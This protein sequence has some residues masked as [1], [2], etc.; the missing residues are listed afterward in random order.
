MENH[1]GRKLLRTEHVHHINEIKSDNRLENLSIIDE[2]A[3]HREHVS[4]AF[5]IEQAKI[6]YDSGI[7]YRKLSDI[8]GVARQ[9]IR[10]C[11]VRRGWHVLGRT[12][13]NV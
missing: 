3:H 4:P 2:S 9:N 10:A 1:I 13:K 5:D 8:F 12:R 7:G 11:F 6:L